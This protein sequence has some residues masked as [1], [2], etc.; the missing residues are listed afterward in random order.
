MCGIAGII[1]AVNKASG[2]ASLI[3]M[4]NVIQHRG[5]DSN[6]LWAT[7]GFAF[8]MQRLSIIDLVGGDQPIWTNY[9]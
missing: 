2:E 7:D 8:G 3:K 9:L 1:G 4:L 5:P 6:G